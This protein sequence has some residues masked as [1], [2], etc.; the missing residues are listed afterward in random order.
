LTEEATSSANVTAASISGWLEFG[1]V[2]M[3]RNIRRFYATSPANNLVEDSEF[4]YDS[5]H[6]N[7]MVVR[8][9]IRVSAMGIRRGLQPGRW[10]S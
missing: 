2:L 7:S 1:S 3:V 6:A 9:D 10:V 4:V 5:T 8:E